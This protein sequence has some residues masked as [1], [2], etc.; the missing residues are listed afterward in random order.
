[1]NKRNVASLIV[2]IAGALIGGLIW[3]SAYHTIWP[4][5]AFSGFL[6]CFGFSLS[7]SKITM[8]ESRQNGTS[9]G[10]FFG[11]LAGALTGLITGI[12]A[13]VIESRNPDYANH[14]I[15]DLTVILVPGIVGLLAGGLLGAPAGFITGIVFFRTKLIRK[16]HEQ[17]MHDD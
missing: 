12:M 11:A 13:G 6:S 2:G 5:G 17:E 8:Q 4:I 7:Y 3:R 15:S 1:M 14:G 9:L 16:S 10:W